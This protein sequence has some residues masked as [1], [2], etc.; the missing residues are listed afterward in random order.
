M[1]IDFLKPVEPA[2]SIKATIHKNGKMGF[3]KSA[4]KK[5]ELDEGKFM[6]IGINS[7]DKNDENLYVVVKKFD[8]GESLKV[9]KAGQYHYLNSKALFD[10]LKIDYR[11]KKIIYDVEDFEY[12]GVEMYKFVKRELD[13]DTSDRNK[14]N[15][16]SKA[17]NPDEQEESGTN[18]ERNY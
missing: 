2:G 7:E 6:Q 13:R 16:T 3:S 17:G 12:N 4:S 18:E 8:N 14:S 5:F 1:K 15:D 9:L 11:H 10:M